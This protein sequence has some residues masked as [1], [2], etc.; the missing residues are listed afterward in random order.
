MWRLGRK[1]GGQECI[2]LLGSCNL[3]PQYEWFKQHRFISLH[4]WRLEVQGQAAGLVET[5]G[6]SPWLAG[7]C[8]LAVSACH[9]PSV[10]VCVLI[11]SSFRDTILIGSGSML[12]TSF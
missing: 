3:E 10:H 12:V 4:F 8:L 6:L 7:G 11:S 5:Q 2:N 1:R 9:P